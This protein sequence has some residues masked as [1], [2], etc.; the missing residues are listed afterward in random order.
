MRK[1]WE[2]V[3]LDY[4]FFQFLF[5]FVFILLLIEGLRERDSGREEM[6]SASISNK[7]QYVFMILWVT[8]ESIQNQHPSWEDKGNI[9]VIL[10]MILLLQLE[11]V[12]CI[13]GAI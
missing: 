12:Y 11:L 8:N 9:I 1:S 6:W 13:P 4:P 5:H 3:G 2:K 7:D 10:R